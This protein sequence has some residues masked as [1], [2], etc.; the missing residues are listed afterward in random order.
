MKLNSDSPYKATSVLV[1]GASGFIGS[2]LCR[3]LSKLGAQVTGAYLSN[4]P[5]GDDAEWLR[6]DLTDLDAVRKAIHEIRPDFIFHLAGSAQGC[7]ELDAV[8]PTFENNLTSTIHILVAAQEAGCCK[9][10]VITN[11]QE[12]PERGDPKAV[13]ASPY[14]ASKFASSAYARMFNALYGFPVVIARVFMVYGPEQKDHNKLVPYTI[15][16]ALDGKAPELSSGGRRLDWVYVSDVVEGLLRLG[17]KSGIEGQTIDLGT[18]QTHT[19]KATVEEILNQIDP[20]LEGNF[21]AVPDRIMEQEPIA[22][23]EETMARVGWRAQVSLKEGLARTIAWYREYR[24]G[25]LLT[26]AE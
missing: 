8:V 9:R 12:E 16:Q 7:R 2:H 22:D 23:I 11:S 5:N 26:K 20:T 18:G 3:H 17:S 25:N 24:A 19:I 10:L 14:A 6:L 13:P 4:I 1:T 15:L 21:G